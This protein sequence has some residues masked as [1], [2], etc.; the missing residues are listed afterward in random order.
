[1][2]GTAEHPASPGNLIA[3]LLE[4]PADPR[5]LLQLAQL[6]LAHRAWDEAE[7]VLM[8]AF[9]TVP[10]H[11][12]VLTHLSATYAG[13]GD[14]DTAR[15]L[16][17]SALGVV[18]PEI[19][20]GPHGAPTVLVLQA[21]G[22]QPFRPG[23]GGAATMPVGTN[24]HHFVDRA[25]FRVVRAFAEN[26][27]GRP[28]AWEAVGPVDVVLNLAVDEDVYGRQF[29]MLQSI[30]D[31]L[32]A[33][34]VNPPADCRGLGR[35]ENY[36]RLHDIPGLVFPRTARMPVGD[37]SEAALA[38]QGFDY[39]LILRNTVDHFGG[40]A[41]LARGPG[42]LLAFRDRVTTDETYVIQYIDNRIDRAGAEPV[43]RRLR[44]AFFAGR[45][46]PVN[47]HYDSGWNVHGRNR[48]R[49]MAPGSPGFEQERAF[50]EDWRS[51][52]GPEAE[53]ALL[54]VARRTPLDYVGIDFTLLPDGR[55]LVFEVN[56]AMAL[57]TE[58]ARSAPHLQTS[59]D[60]YRAE[61]TALLHA[62]IAEGSAARA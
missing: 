5:V 3:A 13:R 36:G 61:L 31:R 23:A 45:P 37:L 18:M 26:L 51:F 46:V 60:R 57:L 21:T 27:V 40:D 12:L 38:G 58:H 6:H 28:G 62:R 25:A 22:D 32:G 24:L 54:E 10:S 9:A 8:R 20:P 2:T 48:D 59:I 53:A 29:P 19:E 4:R 11:P 16:T 43:W 34:V 49:L 52:V 56:P 15:A 44:V 42:D 14:G 39:P 55:A 47:L 1:M 35:A 50:L 17:R 33:P 41:V 7:T 30:L